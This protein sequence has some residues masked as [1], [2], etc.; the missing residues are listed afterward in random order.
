MSRLDAYD[1][2]NQTDTQRRMAHMMREGTVSAVDPRTGRVRVRIGDLETNWLR[3][4]QGR[5]GGNMQTWSMPA[6]GEQVM[7]GS[8]SGDLS[9]AVVLCSM[10]SESNPQAGE[11][12]PVARVKF[13]DGTVVEYDHSAHAMRIKGPTL[14][15]LEA[16]SQIALSGDVRI[17]GN[18][19]VMGT[20]RAEG[21]VFSASGVWPLAAGSVDEMPENTADSGIG[22]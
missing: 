11:S 14:I 16:G 9:Q 7:V 21:Q 6:E 15:K 19:Q 8:V 2:L 3:V 18:L 22:A 17:T 12:G 20:I 10:F 13:P 1:A 5:A 4:G